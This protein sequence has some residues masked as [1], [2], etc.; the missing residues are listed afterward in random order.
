MLFD[1]SGVWM[2]DDLGGHG[3]DPSTLADEK[4]KGRADDL[5]NQNVAVS[6][7]GALLQKLRGDPELIRANPEMGDGKDAYTRFLKELQEKGVEVGNEQWKAKCESEEGLFEDLRT[8]KATLGESCL[9]FR[10]L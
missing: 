4:G 10:V 6:R 9:G 5:A 8:T 2:F 1:G 3:D 7:T